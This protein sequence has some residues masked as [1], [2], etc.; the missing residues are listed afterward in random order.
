MIIIT[1]AVNIAT[2]TRLWSNNNLPGEYDKKIKCNIFPVERTYYSF[3]T[4]TNR[5]DGSTIQIN[6]KHGTESL[7]C[8][9]HVDDDDET[10]E[11]KNGV[12]LPGDKKKS[13]SVAN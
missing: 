7:R 9:L 1:I 3:K 11:W 13:F 5:L 12:Y 6:R 8:Y 4:L 2:T 10:A